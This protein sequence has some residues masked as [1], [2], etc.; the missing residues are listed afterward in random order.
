MKDFL[1]DRDRFGR[2]RFIRALGAGAATALAGCAGAPL[3]ESG[4]T[5]PSLTRATAVNH[6]AYAVTDYA[7]TRDFYVG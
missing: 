4:A 7:R 2:R 6:V 1:D 3:T 5:R